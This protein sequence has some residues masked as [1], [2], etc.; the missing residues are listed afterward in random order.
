MAV[1]RIGLTRLDDVKSSEPRVVEYD[2]Q[3]I[4]QAPKLTESV[5]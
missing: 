4:S 1:N 5:S 2:D 3:T